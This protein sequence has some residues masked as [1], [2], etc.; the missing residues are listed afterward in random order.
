MDTLLDGILFKKD[1]KRFDH[2]EM[3]GSGFARQYI[4]NNIIRDGIFMVIENYAR[5]KVTGSEFSWEMLVDIIR[6]DEGTI[7]RND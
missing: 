1:K 5:T 6:G 7:V 4:G 3:L 2:I